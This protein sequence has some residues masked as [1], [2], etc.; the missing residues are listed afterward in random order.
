[1]IQN[2]VFGQ[3]SMNLVI[4]F[5]INMANKNKNIDYMDNSYVL[6]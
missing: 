5:L 6:F 2:F 3:L 1:M 4:I